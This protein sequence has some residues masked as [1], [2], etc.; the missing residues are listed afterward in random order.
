MNISTYT[1]SIAKAARESSRVIAQADTKRKSLALNYLVEEL[2]ANKDSIITANQ[3]DM[4]LANEN[5]VD[6]AFVARLEVTDETFQRMI[7][8]LQSVEKLPDPIGTITDLTYQPSGIQV[9][10]MRSPIGVICMIY[11]SRPNVTIEAASLCIKSGNACILRGGSEAI[12][13]NLALASCIAKALQ[14]AQLPETIIQVIDSTDRVIVD[15]LLGLNEYIDVVIPRGGKGLIKLI[16]EKS[17]IPVIKHLDGICHTYIDE[18]VNHDI[19]VSVP[20]NAKNEKHAVCNAMETL[21]ISEKLSK[22]VTQRVIE[23]LNEAQIDIRVCEKLHKLFPD[24]ELATEED[25]ST[26]YLGPILSARM[27]SGIDEA[28]TH[29]NNYGSHHTD[30]I[31]T[32]NYNKAHKFLAAVDSATVMINASS[33]FSDGFEFGLGAEIGI[34]TDKLHARGPVGLHGL[35]NEKFIVFG[36]GQTRRR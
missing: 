23:R 4:T 27:V 24:L 1:Q 9:G 16:T 5:K 35:T 15:A 18:E 3:Q 12:H 31:L 26:E 28:I 7:D 10:K 36:Q 21:L 25:W 30:V 22:S 20:L 34:S 6:S 2:K 14:Q 8:S 29:I 33:Q 19:A 32:S 17:S 13:T 11:E